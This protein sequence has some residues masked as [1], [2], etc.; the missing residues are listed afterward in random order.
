MDWY[1]NAPPVEQQEKY[2]LNFEELLNNLEKGA[3]EL[4]PNEHEI[5]HGFNL[6]GEAD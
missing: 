4:S 1:S 3:A 2:L 6:G 5:L